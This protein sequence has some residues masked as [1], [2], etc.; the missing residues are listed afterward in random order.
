MVQEKIETNVKKMWTMSE[1]DQL[2]KEFKMHG[3]KWI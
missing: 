2:L 1:D 3:E